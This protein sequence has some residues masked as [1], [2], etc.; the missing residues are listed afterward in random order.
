MFIKK[1]KTDNIHIL[2]GVNNGPMIGLLDSII[3]NHVDKNSKHIEDF[4]PNS[5]LDE[6]LNAPGN[7]EVFLTQLPERRV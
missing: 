5:I 7:K 3:E 6:I 2:R 4:M 1:I